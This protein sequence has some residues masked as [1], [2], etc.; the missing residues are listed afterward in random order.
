MSVFATPWI[1]PAPLAL[2]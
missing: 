2:R 1:A